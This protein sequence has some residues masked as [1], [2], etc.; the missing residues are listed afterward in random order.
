MHPKAWR[1]D[2]WPLL[3]CTCEDTLPL[4][5]EALATALGRVGA[6]PAE[7]D[8]EEKGDATAASSSPTVAC[9]RQLCRDDLGWFHETLALGS[10]F[11]V[12][13]GFQAPLFEDLARAAVEKA[14]QQI[15]PPA[16]TGEAPPLSPPPLPPSQGAEPVPGRPVCVDL[17][18]TAGWSAAADRSAAKMAALLA[19]AI[20]GARTDP[21]AA[22]PE[23]SHPASTETVTSDGVVLVLGQGQEALSAAEALAE[24]LDVTLLVAPGTA[25]V[26][27]SRLTVPIY[28]GRVRCASGHLGA[29][30]LSVD[31]FAQI[32]PSSRD[33]LRFESPRDGARSQCDLILDLRG[34]APLFPG[35]PVRPG[36]QRPDPGDPVQVQKALATLKTL[37]G[38]FTFRP[39]VHIDPARCIHRRSGLES[40]RRCLDVCPTGALQPAPPPPPPGPDNWQT[41]R[42]GLDRASVHL[43]PVRCGDCGQCAAL[44]PMGAAIWTRPEDVRL[45]HALRRL[46]QAYKAADGPAMAGAPVLLLH[47]QGW[48]AA[49]LASFA[50][51]GPGLPPNLLPFSLPSLGRVGLDLLSLALAWGAAG[52]AL[53]PPSDPQE[54]L[55]PTREALALLT[56]ILTALGYEKPGQ[57]ERLLWLEGPDPTRHSDT[58]WRWAEQAAAWPGRAE[59]GFLPMGERSTVLRLAFESLAE[60][61]PTPCE[62]VPLPQ[63]APLGAVVLTDAAGC[64]LCQAC[65]GACPTRALSANSETP[66]LRFTESRCIQCGLC[67]ALCPER[68]MALDP[69]LL[70]RDATRPVVLK[71]EEPFACVRC[72][73]LFAT[74]SG[75]EAIV[76]RL[77]GQHP[78]FQDEAA[79]ERLKMCPDC[80]VRDQFE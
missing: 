60:A 6:I 8:G 34:E 47:D 58:L 63:G 13:C 48:G 15:A 75:I 49:A 25:L 64:T 79:V 18:E 39:A 22:S 78:M 65:A 11:V 56:T 73:T 46:L 2:A 20:E 51:A 23:P 53:L 72:G 45:Y 36:Y 14:Q 1:L 62:S 67:V 40:C 17:R 42:D 29:F 16:P 57:A 54:S 9:V 35:W 55:A 37:V 24:S 69:R 33:T 61:A 59:A 70:C 68:V 32:L 28:S 52:I 10:S 27:P 77:A 21:A 71:E 5:T 41:D 38:R 50:Q 80:R 19:A 4:K 66:Q 30:D 12:A 31:A 44:C 7:A 3:L 26:P 74:K 76:K 43:D